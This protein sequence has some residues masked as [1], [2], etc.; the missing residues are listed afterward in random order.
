MWCGAALDEARLVVLLVHGRDQTPEWVIEHVAVRLA[1]PDVAFVAPIAPHG[2]WYPA[3][4]D[5]PW[6]DNRPDLD[7]SLVMLATLESNLLERGLEP[8]QV[9]LCGFSQGASLVCT[10][11]AACPG[12]RHSVIAFTGGLVGP[13]DDIVAVSGRLE[14]LRVYLS[15]SSAD[16][17][18]TM[19]RAN[20]TADA[21][22]AAG[23]E[24]TLE[25]FTDREHEV[26][27]I[28]IDRARAL[29]A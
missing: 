19:E 1:L 9:V 15:A 14:G 13:D 21:F 25:L 20:V 23:A 10:Y 17:W 28:E 3:T 29:L 2:R 4:L 5:A 16:P 11:A 18:L 7:D 12:R 8:G 22:R 6:H 27:D 26:S 24:V